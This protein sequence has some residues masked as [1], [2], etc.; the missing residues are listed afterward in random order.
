[1]GLETHLRMPARDYLRVQE[2]C[3]T[4]AVYPTET[5]AVC[6]AREIKSEAGKSTRF[7]PTCD[8]A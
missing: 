4:A 6:R 2:P 8:V 1:M 3:R 5:A 7:A